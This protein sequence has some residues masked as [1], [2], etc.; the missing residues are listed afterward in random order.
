MKPLFKRIISKAR[1]LVR[2]AAVPAAIACAVLATCQPAKAQFIAP[3]ISTL[4]TNAVVRTNANATVN[5]STNLFN[6]FNFTHG[7]PVETIITSTNNVGTTATV[8]NF[9]DL[10]MDNT[11]TNWTTVQPITAIGTCNGT[12][13]ARSIS[14][15]P[16]S[17]FDGCYAIRLSSVQTGA[18]NW[19]NVTTR[20]GVTP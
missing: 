11:F 2:A 1:R 19:I 16:A 18:T 15:I 8:T 13:P 3:R 20:I 12:T 6:A 10:C 14:I 17:L 5:I 9:F 4:V 7:L